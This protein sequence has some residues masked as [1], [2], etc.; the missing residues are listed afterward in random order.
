MAGALGKLPVTH[1]EMRDDGRLEKPLVRNVALLTAPEASKGR[2]HGVHQGNRKAKPMTNEAPEQE[3]QAWLNADD[4]THFGEHEKRLQRLVDRCEELKRQQA[5]AVGAAYEAA[6]KYAVIATGDIELF[7][8]ICALADTDALER[9]KQ[10]EREKCVCELEALAHSFPIG[11]EDDQKGRCSFN[12]YMAAARALTPSDAPAALE[13]RDARVWDAAI[14]AVKVELDKI[15]QAS[16]WN[17][18]IE[19][20]NNCLLYALDDLKKGTPDAP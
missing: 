9:V 7:D 5:E 14:E 18:S 2:N 11:H 19:R 16:C 17:V 4:A 1:E 20:C 6:A 3:A 8:P 12:W 13:A 10:E 15:C